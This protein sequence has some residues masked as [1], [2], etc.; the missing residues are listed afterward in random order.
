MKSAKVQF[1]NVM[2]RHQKRRYNVLM[3]L[4]VTFLM[5]FAGVWF[6]LGNVP[7]NFHGNWHA[8]DFVLFLVVSYV[9]W[10]Q[11]MMDTVLWLI[12]RAM[13]NPKRQKAAAGLKVA[14]ITTF[15]P[16]SE[17]L[18]LLENI[19][20]AMRRADYEHDTWLLDEGNDP[21]ARK[22]CKKY[23]VKYF[24]RKGVEKYNQPT[25][26]KFATKTKGGNHNAWYDAHG[27]AYEVVAQIDTDFIPRKD[28]L[29]R[30]LGYFND[31]EIAFVGTPQIYGNEDDSDIARGAAEQ[32]FTFYGPI[33]RGLSGRDSCMMLGANHVVRVSAL[34]EIG[35]YGAH[36]TEDLLTGMVMH[37]RRFKSIYVAEPLAVGEGPN[38]WQDFFIQ[39]RRW[40]QG[41]FDIL[42]HQSAKLTSRMHRRQQMYYLIMQQH[43][44]SGITIA[45]GIVLLSLYFVFGI[46]V[47]QVSPL[48]FLATYVPLIATNFGISTWLQR[49]NI[50]PDKER[51]LLPY[52]KMVSIAAQPVY[53]V[54]LLS[55]LTGKKLTFKVTPKHTTLGLSRTP[56]TLFMPHLVL[57]TITLLDI[58]LGVETGRVS[59]ILVFWAALN[60]TLMYYIA[61]DAIAGTILDSITTLRRKPGAEPA[62]L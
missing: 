3:I 33:L 18:E 29:T 1:I 28:F 59:P 16:D 42:F 15:V 36:L 25:G 43:Y 46:Q 20:P 26:H 54:A 7:D 55:A 13:K 17:P 51:G 10:H 53:M 38:T 23:G 34:K 39:Q 48:L 2:S 8:M 56:V 31:P 5:L 9:V 35:Y 27:Y 61:F 37:S 57:G 30:T 52:G 44:L 62:E 12:A 21:Q 50:R 24:T 19:L 14:F 11:I 58:M 41:C 40:A 32:G 22:L 6:N 49:F 45:A 4:A 47:T 60:T